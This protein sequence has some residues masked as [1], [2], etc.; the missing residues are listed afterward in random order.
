MAR[1]FVALPAGKEGMREAAFQYQDQVKGLLSK[2]GFTPDPGLHLTLRFL[3]DVDCEKVQEL[4]GQLWDISTQHNPVRLR[5]A[6]LGMFDDSRV[7]FARMT[8]DVAALEQL[9]KDVDAAASAV[10]VPEA[11]YPFTTP[12]ITLGRVC[13][14]PGCGCL[15]AAREAVPG[16]EVVPAELWANEIALYES[17]KTERGIQYVPNATFWLRKAG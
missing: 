8:G 15:A 14:A 3:G 5:V 1:M 9:Q 17:V 12:H 7:V 4:V 16:V 6:N 11:D 13:G 2:G 10:G